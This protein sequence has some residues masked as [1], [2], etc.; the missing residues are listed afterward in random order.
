[1]DGTAT[2]RHGNIESVM[3]QDKVLLEIVEKIGGVT[4]SIK[5]IESILEKNTASAKAMW[6]KVE[7]HGKWINFM[8]GAVSVLVASCGYVI[9]W[10]KHKFGM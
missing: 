6:K 2:I 9:Y 10:V 3:D 4:V 5:N 7:N 8:K 1:L